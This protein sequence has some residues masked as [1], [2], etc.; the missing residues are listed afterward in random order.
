MKKFI[1]CTLAAAIAASVSGAALAAT[2]FDR[3]IV[4]EEQ[5]VA[6]LKRSGKIAPNATPQQITKA[7]EEYIQGTQPE[8]DGVF[9]K[10]EKSQKANIL[11]NKQN[12]KKFGTRASFYAETAE[13]T[14]T[15]KVLALLID[16]P[17]L[18]HDDN[19]ITPEMTGMYYPEYP[20]THYDGLLFGD[21]YK[22][23]N[24]ETLMTMRQFYEQESGGTYSVAGKAVG[25][26]RAK[27]PA[28][29]YGAHTENGGKDKDARSLVREAL[30][31]LAA[32]PSIDLA[33]YDLED[34]YD[35]DKDGN[36]LEPDGLIDHLMIFH[37]SVGEEAGGGALG[38]DAIWSH[39]WNLGEH[40]HELDGTE[41]DIPNG[42]SGKRW[43]GKYAAYDYTIQPID[44]AAGV[45][46]HE[47]AHD[48]GLPDEYDT[49]Y[50]GKGEP[51]SMWSVMS[52]GSWAGKI[53]GSEPVAFSSWAKEYL[54]AK[55]GGNWI[56]VQQL[57]LDDVKESK[58]VVRITE[59]VENNDGINHVRID[60][61][62]Q[63]I[64]EVLPKEGA[65]HYWSQ[66]GDNLH[67]R[68][69]TKVTL[70]TASDIKLTFD[71]YFEIEKDYDYAR[72]LVNGTALKGN[73]TTDSD[74]HSLGLVPGISSKS[75]EHPDSVDG[76]VPAVFDL[77]AYSGQEVDIVFAYDTDGGWVEQGLYTDNVKVVADGQV[78][79]A[80]DAETDNGLS[81]AGFVKN[82][83]YGYYD[84]YYMLQWRSHKGVDGGLKNLRRYGQDYSFEPGLVVW[85][86][87]TAYTDNW[88]GTHP[89]KGWL[90]VV[91]ADQNA[92]KWSADDSA[93]VTRFQVRDATFSLNNQAPMYL[94][95]NGN[96]LE[97]Q[98][99]ESSSVFFDKADYS[100]PDVPD[101][102]RLIPGYGLKVEVLS[103][104]ADNSSA[105]IEISVQEAVSASFSM[106]R[107]E[108]QVTFLNNSTVY[109]TN[110]KYQWDF[111][112]GNS[113]TVKNAV[114][115]YAK[116]GS[117]E[118]TL[119]V[120]DEL[121][122]VSVSTQTVTVKLES[123][124]SAYLLMMLLAPLAFAR[125]KSKK[126]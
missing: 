115:E 39:R 126:A 62:P 106:V 93:A 38:K 40:P 19:K 113:S 82:D 52:S 63:K 60:L 33:D 110:A 4:N 27:H 6:H 54:F 67:T 15:D 59:T 45:C 13:N 35:L 94:D 84:H 80:D 34:R 73:V 102:G 100:S 81:L 89:G 20:V 21:G 42:N 125:R 75:A 29:Y 41:H 44:A 87:D 9:A 71:A 101:A 112:D 11:L 17:D 117:Y 72:V 121:G 56:N 46:S 66:K 14:R 23:P 90:G 22:G 114:H 103:Q 47:Y 79:L 105:I 95:N 83:G 96:I 25:W 50:S 88:T 104:E 3:A 31:A 122:Q 78:V 124:G 55:L 64:E 68:M 8:D 7:L 37:S 70:P 92:I 98:H 69:S 74:P 49:Q 109:G 108:L 48:L 5:I 51:V 58:K 97:D 85:Y 32:D 2:P 77:T 111:G 91:D 28:A 57:A 53:P 1:K 107:D 10:E 12:L 36:V 123:A 43:G 16:F 118:V 61:P 120:T 18:P 65:F 76:W 24:D 30:D 99:L 116:D 119:T 86:A 26:Y